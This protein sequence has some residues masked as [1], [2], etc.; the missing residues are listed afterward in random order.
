M[1]VDPAYRK[2]GWAMLRRIDRQSL[3]IGHGTLAPAR[4]DI[5]AGLLCIGNAFKSIIEQWTPDLV[6]LEQPGYWMFR[7]DSNR[8]S[9]ELMAMVRGL[10]LTVCASRHTAACM[11]DV[12]EAR[13][14]IFGNT[15]RK[16]E[17]QSRLLADRLFSEL[18]GRSELD[19]NVAD[20]IVMGLYG[21]GVG[22]PY[23][24]NGV[25]DP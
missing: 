20:A 21:I 22:N 10:M 18:I 19:H 4:G 8:R 15:V 7:R 12:Q 14:V 25:G 3:L 1:G 16:Q 6:V 23:I 24:S 9:I 2:T 13:R 11:V 17:V 5:A